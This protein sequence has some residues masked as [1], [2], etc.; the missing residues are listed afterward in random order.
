M[1]VKETILFQTPK[2]LIIQTAFIGDVVL[3]TSVAEKLHTFYPDSEIHF[4]L[5]KG[6]ESLLKNHPFIKQVIVWDKT[7][8]KQQ[9]LWKLIGNVRKEKFT[10]VINLHR[11]ATSGLITFLSGAD[12]KIGFDKNPLSFFYTKKVTHEISEPYTANPVHEIERNQLLIKDLTDAVTAKPKLYPSKEDFE[13]TGVYK[14]DKYICIAP[15]SVWF[16][17]QFPTHKWVELIKNLP[18]DLNVYLLGGNGD[19]EMADAIIQQSRGVNLCGQL[20]FLQ[21]AALMKDAMMNYVNDSG[22]LH[23]ASAVNAP[24]TAVFCSTVPAFGFGPTNE[25]GKVVEITERLSCRPCGLHGK[26]NCPEGHFNCANNIKPEQLLWW[27]S[28]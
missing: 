21:S 11:F 2:F 4:L 10:H 20:N 15:S 14:T 9:N 16:T 19:K 27:T 26:K 1:Q 28:K 3:G 12:N 5:R 24:V 22:P 7:E 6:N 18:L 8:N 23:F 17:K 13:K 25:N